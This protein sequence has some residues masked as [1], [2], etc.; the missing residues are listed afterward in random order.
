MMSIENDGNATAK[1]ADIAEAV[2]LYKGMNEAER[3]ECR[4]MLAYYERLGISGQA[5]DDEFACGEDDESLDEEGVQ[6]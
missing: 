6:P 3:R 2:E 5:L 4:E 1:D